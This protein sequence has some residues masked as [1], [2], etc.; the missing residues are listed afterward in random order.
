MLIL[1]KNM[2]TLTVITTY[3]LLCVSIVKVSNNNSSAAVG[4]DASSLANYP[5]FSLPS[6]QFPPLILPY[7]FS[8]RNTR[9]YKAFYFYSVMISAGFMDTKKSWSWIFWSLF[10]TEVVS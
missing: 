7:L 2:Y 1:S 6:A 3:L 8:F 10:Y 9:D 5:L 4:D